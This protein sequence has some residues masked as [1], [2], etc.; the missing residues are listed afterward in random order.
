MAP[1]VASRKADITIDWERL[2]A[3][4]SPNCLDEGVFGELRLYGVLRSLRINL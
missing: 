3:L 1:L 4:Y 2:P